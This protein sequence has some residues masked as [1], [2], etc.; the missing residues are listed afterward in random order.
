M[1]DAGDTGHTMPAAIPSITDLGRHAATFV[2][3]VD[4]LPV[5][6]GNQPTDRKAQQ[7][8]L[9][10][11]D[12]AL[13][14]LITF[15]RATSLSDAATQLYAGYMAADHATNHDLTVEEHVRCADT[16][17]RLF[18]ST[19]PLVAAAAKLDLAEIGAEY[20]VEYAEREFPAEA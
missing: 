15:Y 12:E 9:Y 3:R 5:S 8:V 2:R 20:I 10:E 4:T 18:I 6:G 14:S 13:R 17:R 11:R 19:L 1:R 16:L 7:N